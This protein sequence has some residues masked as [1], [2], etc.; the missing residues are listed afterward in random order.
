V[1]LI[2]GWFV[3]WLTL[4]QPADYDA[5]LREWLCLSRHWMGEQRRFGPRRDAHAY[6]D[7]R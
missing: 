6:R 3:H 2:P 4:R 7:F 5:E 1:E